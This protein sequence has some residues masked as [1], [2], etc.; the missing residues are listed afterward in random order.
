[1][2]DNN[3]SSVH[4]FGQTFE[5]NLQGVDP[6]SGRP[7]ANRWKS[8]DAG[9]RAG[10]SLARRWARPIV[11]VGHSSSEMFGDE[12]ART[13]SASPPAPASRL[14]PGLS[15]ALFASSISAKPSD[16]SFL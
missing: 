2:H 7:D 6:S 12:S 16:N 8:L 15:S 11:I 14:S 4:V 10:T 9:L 1:M 5:K 3:E 13:R